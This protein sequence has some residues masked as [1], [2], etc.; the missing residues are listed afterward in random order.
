M[1]IFKS[2]S[3]SLIITLSLS[4][5]YSCKD[6]FDPEL[7][8]VIKSEDF[9]NDWTDFRSAEM[10]LYSL[11]Q[12]LV[13]QIVILGELRADHMEI[14]ENADPDL[15]EIYNFQF[16]EENPYVS[17]A[18]FYKLIANCNNM[19]RKL[20][21]RKPFIGQPEKI[22][23]LNSDSNADNNYIKDNYDNLHG[24]VLAMRAW[25]YFNAVRIY[26]KIPYI[27]SQVVGVDQIESYLATGKVI[28]TDT[29]IS[30]GQDGYW[31]NDTTYTEV[32]Y[33]FDRIW[34]NT[35]AI[36]D[37]FTQQ[38][39]TKVISEMNGQFTSYRVG[40]NYNIDNIN[41]RTWE[42]KVWNQYAFHCLL[43]EMYFTKGDLYRAEEAFSN[44]VYFRSTT[45]TDRYLIT[46]GASS[47]NTYYT[48]IDL[49]EHIYIIPF[50]K[51]NKQTNTLQNLFDI[52]SPNS[53]KIKPS[54]W[55]VWLYETDWNNW[56]YNQ[57]KT[58]IIATGQP[59]DYVRGY[60][61]AYNYY[62]PEGGNDANTSGY[63][64]DST[65]NKL[66][67]L[68]VIGKEFEVDNYMENV[69]TVIYKYTVGNGK[70]DHDNNYTVY[71]AGG[72]H[73]YMAELM[74]RSYLLGDPSA[75]KTKTFIA[76][77]IMGSGQYKKIGESDEYNSRSR[78]VRG[79]ANRFEVQPFHLGFKRDPFT[80]EL[81]EYTTYSIDK[82]NDLYEDFIVEERA[83]EL[84]FE[85]DRFNT[86]MRVSKRRGD[87]GYLAHKVARKFSTDPIH[88]LKT[89]ELKGQKALNLYEYLKNNEQNWYVPFYIGKITS[90]E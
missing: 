75:G 70:F 85:G 44:I 68:K 48:G 41:D 14:T 9:F 8:S 81:D 42:V 32:T 76:Q 5:I 12:Q 58:R 65:V 7:Q 63:L 90:E 17:P 69:D 37:T 74:H 22:A 46:S 39:T 84:S 25:A 38:L 77:N 67:N 80:N 1:K 16:S 59:N 64:K 24:S 72:I 30:Y 88:T 62:Y 27:P 43:G 35:D 83:R 15:V 86:L 4:S 60:N 21:A 28:V 11:Q 40:V 78:G 29:V 50:S 31:D 89:G 66:L 26:G 54:N 6:F 45:E 20:E 53:Y 23:A 49:N 19:L 33:D 82:G 57:D 13:D 3:I 55:G 79:R 10:G 34:L 47:Y 2:L 52:R 56:R 18:N 36:I 71:R 51:V 61:L 73:M 87:N